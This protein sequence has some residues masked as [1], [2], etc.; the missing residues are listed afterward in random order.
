M[1]LGFSSIKYVIVTSSEVWDSWVQLVPDIPVWTEFP[2][3]QPTLAP[4]GVKSLH[5]M[6]L[7]SSKTTSS[8]RWATWWLHRGASIGRGLL[9]GIRETLSKTTQV[10]SI[11]W[12]EV[13]KGSG[14]SFQYHPHAQQRRKFK[15][16]CCSLPACTASGA[17]TSVQHFKTSSCFQFLQ[18]FT[19]YTEETG[20]KQNRIGKQKW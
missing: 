4:V 10:L 19:F 2:D 18:L 7:S 16:W 1:L 17:N 15:T 8:C 3:C 14:V 20:K 5:V 12:G 9:A 11:P 6:V 13:E